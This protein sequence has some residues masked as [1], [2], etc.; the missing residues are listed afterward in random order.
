MKNKNIF[1]LY[2][3]L[4]A[5]LADM[6]LIIK[7]FPGMRIYSKPLIITSLIIYFYKITKP[8]SWTL[9]SKA[10]LG[11][12]VFSLLG[13]ILLLWN[14]LFIYGLGA[15][16]IAQVC[17]II[18]FKVAQQNPN[19]IAGVNF[20]RTFFL[21][22]PIYIIAAFIYYLIH[23]NL[24]SL[25]IPV[26]V[27]IIVIVSMLSTARERFK[28]CNPDSFWQVFIGASLFFVSDGIIAI[29]KFYRDF[30]ESGILIMGTYVIA[31]LLIV[32]GIRSHLIRPE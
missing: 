32:M 1:W 27:Y 30:Q 3:F 13:D 17:Y 14:Q 6:A 28:K 20:I 24:G 19:R 2:L 10:T 23:Q 26:V 4:F 7:D 11:A 16:F 29:S 31:Q 22:L 12:L 15:F 18:A 21:N 9:L 5:S 8:V 25:K